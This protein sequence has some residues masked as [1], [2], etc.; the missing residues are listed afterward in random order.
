MPSEC[1]IT[2]VNN[3]YSR[4]KWYRRKTWRILNVYL[5]DRGIWAKVLVVLN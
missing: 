5:L 2:G 1:S 4:H 3:S